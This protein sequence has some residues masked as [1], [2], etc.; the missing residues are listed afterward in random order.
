MVDS[1]HRVAAGLI[2]LVAILTGIAAIGADEL[3]R[4]AHYHRRGVQALQGENLAKARRNFERALEEVPMFP[5]AHIGLGQIAMA[6]QHYERALAHFEQAREG[7]EKIG[8]SLLDLESRRYAEAQNRIALIED[9]I[10]HLQSQ[11]VAGGMLQIRINEMQSTISRLQAID[12]P[13]PDKATEAPGEVYF[14]IGN[15]LFQLRRPAAAI[16]AWE[17]CRAKNPKLAMVYN[18]LAVA[19]VQLGRLEQARTNLARAEK[20][21]FPVNPQFK[22]DLERALAESRAPGSG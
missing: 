20:L 7:F 16:D 1:G 15:A 9:Q 22:L 4:A 19:Y 13:D 17:T 14:H 12:P 5:S 10:R 18:N 3:G 2:A 21:G 6:E 11:G 8:D